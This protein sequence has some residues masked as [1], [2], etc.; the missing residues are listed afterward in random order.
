MS[1]SP[2]KGAGT[3]ERTQCWL[4]CFNKTTHPYQFGFFCNSSQLIIAWHYLFGTF[5]VYRKDK[6]PGCQVVI[7]PKPRD[8]RRQRGG[9]RLLSS[10]SYSVLFLS[11]VTF[12]TQ[13][14]YWLLAFSVTT[15]RDRIGSPWVLKPTSCLSGVAERH[16]NSK[17]LV[18]SRNLPL[19]VRGKK[20]KD[21]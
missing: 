18:K 6:A 2:R 21:I 4:W 10:V 14:W 11:L 12:P 9:K 5:C 16:T 8:W 3:S 1:V 13:H 20:Q 17:W 7:R 15:F 19:A